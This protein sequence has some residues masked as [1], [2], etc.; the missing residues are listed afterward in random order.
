MRAVVLVG[1]EGTRLLPLTETV[2]HPLLPLVDRPLLDP[3]LAHLVHP[4]VDE[5]VMSSPYLA[6]TF[7]PFTASRDAIPSLPWV[8]ERGPLGTGGAIVSALDRLGDEPC[9]ALNGD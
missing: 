3:V 4:G 8:T 9:F 5:V 7:H 1:G 2:P 6:E